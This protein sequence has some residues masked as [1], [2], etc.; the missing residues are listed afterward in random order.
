MLHGQS[1]EAI[2]SSSASKLIPCNFCNPHQPARVSILLQIN[3]VHALASH[4]FKIQFN[5]IILALLDPG[6]KLPRN[7][8]NYQSIRQHIT[9][10]LKL[11]IYTRLHGVTSKN[12]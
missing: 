3:P 11:R 4:L 6:R 2:T 1:A 8:G 10:D 5:V 9:E 7:V 12:E